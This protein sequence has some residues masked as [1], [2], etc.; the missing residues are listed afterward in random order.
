M[1]ILGAPR[2]LTT[3]GSATIEA[4]ANTEK[5]SACEYHSQADTVSG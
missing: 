4:I 5:K 1:D 3:S 2:T